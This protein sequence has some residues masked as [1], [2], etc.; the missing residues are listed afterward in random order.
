MVRFGMVAAALAL[1]ASPLLAQESTDDLKKELEQLRKEVDSLKAVNS[2]KEVPAMGKIDADAMAADDSPVVTLF[3]GTKLSGHLDTAYG[4]SFNRLSEGLNELNT[5]NNPTRTFDNQDHSFYLHAVQ[6]NLERLATKD[7]IV[8]YHVELMFGSDI[9][10]F[11]GTSLGIQEGWIQILAPVGS[12]LDIRVGKMA[13]L[14]GYEVVENTNNLNYSRGV[15]WGQIE[16]ITA[17]GVRATYSFVEQVSATIGFNNGRNLSPVTSINLTDADLDHGKMFEAQLLVKPI[18]DFWVAMNFNVGGS[19]LLGPLGSANGGSSGNGSSADKFYIFNIVAEYKM[20]KLTVALNFDQASSQGVG[21]Q[22]GGLR[23]PQRGLA[24]YAK[25]QLTD[26]FA[27]G[28]RAEYY[29]DQLGALLGA[30]FAPGSAGD[31]GNGA[32]VITLTLTQEMKVAQHL[33][34]RMEFRHDSSNQHIFTGRGENDSAAKGDN[35][36]AFEALL[37]F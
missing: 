24:V 28:V 12:G 36:L 21:N 17:T 5:L 27:T 20:D 1:M 9:K 37:P 19:E 13:S 8:G 23:A 3:K 22:F 32:R 6:L 29:S 30:N 14:I 35:T 7:M 4:F 16:P 26:A 25:Y 31:T 34:L 15:V 33:I 18:K 11:D 10:T 2:T